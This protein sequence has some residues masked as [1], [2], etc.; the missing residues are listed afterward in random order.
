MLVEKFVPCLSLINLYR[1][2][3]KISSEA[4]SSYW[5]WTSLT[6]GI[7]V[8]SRSFNCVWQY[9]ISKATCFLHNTSWILRSD[10][11]IQEIQVISQI[12]FQWTHLSLIKKGT[13][14][15]KPP[16]LLLTQLMAW[17]SAPLGFIRAV[18][19]SNFGRDI[20]FLS[21]VFCGFPECLQANSFLLPWHRPISLPSTLFSNHILLIILKVVAI[22][23]NLWNW[24][25]H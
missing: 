18:S 19:A 11:N 16:L 13:G 25:S 4:V 2:R 21:G 20:D 14:R 22:R 24:L 15:M 6:G 12:N 5:E 8:Y 9:S 17:S 7:S 10:L 23:H 3:F 1:Q